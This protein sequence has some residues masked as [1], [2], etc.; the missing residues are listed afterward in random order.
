MG[1]DW[2]LTSSKKALRDSRPSPVL[3][4][5]GDQVGNRRFYDESFKTL[6]LFFKMSVRPQKGRE[7]FENSD[8]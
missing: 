6:C 4:K 2:S 3:P 5:A 7:E 1:Q 8:L